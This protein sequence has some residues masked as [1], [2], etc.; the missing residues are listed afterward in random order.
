MEKILIGGAINCLNMGDQAR[1]KPSVRELKRLNS[2]IDIALLSHNF[3]NDIKAFEEDD[4]EVLKAPWQR[5]Y[6]RRGDYLWMVIK[7]LS[8]LTKYTLLSFL[9]KVLRV[10]LKGQ[11][12][13][14]D[15]FVDVGGISFADHAG[16][17]TF[18]FSLYCHVL[19]GIVL[20]MPVVCYAQTIGPFQ[21]YRLT[22]NLA[23][24]ILNR[25][26]LITLRDEK[27]EDYLHKYGINKPEIRV[28]A[29]PGF[30]LET[31]DT[32]VIHGILKRAGINKQNK[33][34]IGIVPHPTPYGLGMDYGLLFKRKARDNLETSMGCIQ[35]VAKV[36]DYLVETFDALVVLIPHSTMPNSD[37]IATNNLIYQ[38]MR[39]K[40]GVTLLNA[41]LTPSQ[42][43]GIIARCDL[44]ISQRLH[45]IVY[46]VSTHVPV[47]A[48][49]AQY[50]H[51]IPAVM[52]MVGLEQYVCNIRAMTYA[53]IIA[54][55]NDAWTNRQQIRKRLEYVE[56]TMRESALLNVKLVNDL[57]S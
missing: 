13:Q 7:A 12:S 4:L 33:P 35:Y 48:M 38:G 53:Q 37:D 2:N 25:A 3:E 19:F 51:R 5:T 49:I 29:D 44:L 36:A 6:N 45:P 8:T 15:I 21:K 54:K 39:N 17:I 1:I 14:Y 42:V 40:D 57:L 30:L 34:I 27:S 50:S 20:K 52:K 16:A 55:I 43:R 56:N 23:K 18:F 28:T 46:A 41:E 11:L 32:K 9:N 10:P 24:F 47:I 31:A 26:T 22:R